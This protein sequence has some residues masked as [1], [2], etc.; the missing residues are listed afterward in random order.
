MTRLATPIFD[1]AH[2]KICDQL[3]VHANLYKHARYQDISLICFGDM[4]DEKMQ[5]SDW[6]RTFWS[7]S[8]E[9]KFSHI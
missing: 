4:V 9:Q 5:Q 1:H 3:L 7:I 8:Q 2:Q 6:L